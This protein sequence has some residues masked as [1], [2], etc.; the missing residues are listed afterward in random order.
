MTETRQNTIAAKI[1][2]Q[3]LF[4]A[5]IIFVLVAFLALIDRGS[6][7]S[8][9][10][11]STQNSPWILMTACILFYALCSSILSLKAKQANRYWRDAI[12]SFVLLMVASAATATV[13]SGQSMDEAGS[14]RWLFVVMSVGYLVFL[15]IVRLMKKIVDL[16][17]RQDD[18]LRG[19]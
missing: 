1:T 17:I 6:N 8:G 14:F 11:T 13:L 18:K 16:A 2:A 4:Q 3:P 9:V 12:L 15:T 7:V 19:E 5:A 10:G